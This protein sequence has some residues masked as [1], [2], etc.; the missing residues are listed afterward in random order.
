MHFVW[1]RHRRGGHVEY[2]VRNLEILGQVKEKTR[3][4]F[5]VGMNV[6]L[7]GSAVITV[8]LNRGETLMNANGIVY[9][10]CCC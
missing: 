6:A 5:A 4:F 1:P 10:S 9:C 3:K 8:A 7:S 2:L